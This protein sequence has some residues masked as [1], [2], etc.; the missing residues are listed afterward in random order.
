MLLT[1]ALLIAPVPV[2]SMVA[3]PQISGKINVIFITT[4]LIMFGNIAVFKTQE[5]Q[6]TSFSLLCDCPGTVVLV[7]SS[8]VQCVF[9]FHTLVGIVLPLTASALAFGHTS[10]LAT[11]H[12]CGCHIN[13]AVKNL[14]SPMLAAMQFIVRTLVRSL[15]GSMYT[16]PI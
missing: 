15:K 3:S 5:H 7:F 8:H 10:P 14:L 2:F 13:L 1:R 9:Y 4:K 11:R 6:K 12:S 16:S